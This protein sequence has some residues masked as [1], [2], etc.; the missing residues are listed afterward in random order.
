MRNQSD[1]VA[2]SVVL[3]ELQRLP[4][5]FPALKAQGSA[6]LRLRRGFSGSMPWH[7]AMFSR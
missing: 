6:L 5:A 3:T 7:S 2:A 4:S 1:F